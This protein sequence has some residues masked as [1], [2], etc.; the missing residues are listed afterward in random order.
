MAGGRD[1]ADV[2]AAAV[3]DAVPDPADQRGSWRSRRSRGWA[4][5]W[6]AVFVAEVGDVHRAQTDTL[7]SDF[8]ADDGRER[9]ADLI[10]A[11]LSGLLLNRYLFDVQASPTSMPT[12][13]CR[14]L[15][16]ASEPAIAH[17][18]AQAIKDTEGTHAPVARCVQ[19]IH[20]SDGTPITHD[21]ARNRG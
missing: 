6:G 10:G 15:N 2:P 14:P 8:V 9:R 4:R 18:T 21:N 16:E 11:H 19:K 1:D 13:Y 7:V 12:S 17:S 20:H 5:S 3:P